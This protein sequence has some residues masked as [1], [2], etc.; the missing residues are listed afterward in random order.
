MDLPGMTM[1]V[2]GFCDQNTKY[3]KLHPKKALGKTKAGSIKFG[4]LAWSTNEKTRRCVSPTHTYTK[5]HRRSQFQN[6]QYTYTQYTKKKRIYDSRPSQANAGFPRLF[7]SDGGSSIVIPTN[8]PSK[9]T[10]QTNTHMHVGWLVHSFACIPTIELN[11]LVYEFST[12]TS[13]CH[14][15]SADSGRS[16]HYFHRLRSKQNMYRSNT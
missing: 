14:R 3:L 2:S 8:I 10:Q 15:I 4:L 16:S 7:P 13:Y 1:P 6:T 9:T 5:Y 11:F 12:T